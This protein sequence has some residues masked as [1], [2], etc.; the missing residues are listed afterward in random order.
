MGCAMTPHLGRQAAI[1]L[2]WSVLLPPLPVLA[3]GPGSGSPVRT[4]QPVGPPAPSAT[5]IGPPA[6]TRP[7]F[8]LEAGPR[9]YLTARVDPRVELM[10]ILFRLAGNPEYNMPSSQSP[11]SRR[12]EERF[13]SFREHPAVEQARQ[14][15]ETRGIAF[16]AV[17]SLAVRLEDV[18][19]L[20][21]KV[22]LDSPEN[23][24]DH[25]WKP[26]EAGVFLEKARD[27]VREARF[28]DFLAENKIYYMAAAIRMNEMLARR[29]CREWFEKFFGARPEAG[30]T[31]I[32]GLL[33]GGGN[34]GPSVRTADGQEEFCAILGAHHFDNSGLP[35]FEDRVSAVLVHEFCHSY[36]N[37]LVTRRQDEL[38][39]AGR[40]IFAT[41][42]NAMRRQA[43]GSWRSMMYES[44]VR[45]SVCRYVRAVDGAEAGRRQIREELKRGFRWIEELSDLLGE[46]EAQRDRYPTLESFMPEVV[47]FFNAYAD[48]LGKPAIPNETA[49][50]DW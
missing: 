17:A 8:T 24:L 9:Q 12:V 46:Y 38:E 15:R 48:R 36:T 32:V 11:Y 49:S 37:P 45:A 44:M 33:T 28:T 40:R 43:Y 4:A 10:S 13:G 23:G 16:D 3:A 26:E 2:T 50:P 31:V 34:Y 7:A 27:F 22:P 47:K 5:R 21:A 14:L 18:T 42:A 39:K 25:R 20:Q 35:V 6:S 30:F 19:E 41:C 29:Q 1:L